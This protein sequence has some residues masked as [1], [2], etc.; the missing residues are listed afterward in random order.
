PIVLATNNDGF[1]VQDKFVLPSGSH[2][3]I[4]VEKTGYTATKVDVPAELTAHP[5]NIQLDPV[6]IKDGGN[7]KKA[8]DGTS[9]GQKG[10]KPAHQLTLVGS[11]AA[12]DGSPVSGA[13][14]MFESGGSPPVQGSAYTDNFGN[15]KRVDDLLQVDNNLHV[16]VL[17]NGY[18]VFKQN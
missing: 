3:T 14:V 11:V 16:T 9:P 7:G 10:N 4:Y 5:P 6:P 8:S 18:K 2:L 1:W 13:L 12:P 17:A 15:F